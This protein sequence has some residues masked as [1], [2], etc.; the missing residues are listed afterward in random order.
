MKHI[1][2]FLLTALFA[3]NMLLPGKADAQ[4]PEKMSYQAV[5]RNS[6]NQLVTNQQIA[7]QISI[8]QG[9][10]DGKT[11]YSE[12]QE[13]TTN[14]N[15]LVSIEIGTGTATSDFSTINWANG[16]FFIKTETDPEGGTNYSIT[17]TSQLLSVP[18]ALHAKTAET[19]SGPVNADDPV[20]SDLIT[21]TEN[22]VLSKV[23][24]NAE[25]NI[26][27]NWNEIDATSDAFI[28]NKPKL[29]QVATSGNYN[30]LTNQPVLFDGNYASLTNK[31]TLFDGKY[32]SLTN[33]PS[34]KDT[35][36]TYGFSG[37]Y[38]DLTNQPVLF[39]GKYASL[40]NKPS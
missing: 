37:N 8:I 31:P 26:Q 29:A 30:D 4:A 33:K 38:N 16:P 15:G 39:D 13:P 12:T 21:A 34:M 11:V 5:I 3:G 19:F 35:V 24:L 10:A 14:A 9:S 2:T 17:S 40:T 20:F 22:K 6:S 32:T 7:M 1:F 27:S 23:N 36:D 28:L 18:Y 25:Q